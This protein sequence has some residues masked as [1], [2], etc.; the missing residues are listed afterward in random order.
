[1]EVL[2]LLV[3]QQESHA[4]QKRQRT[5]RPPATAIEQGCLTQTAA[6]SIICVKPSSLHSTSSQTAVVVDVV[7][8]T[9]A[10][11]PFNHGV[12]GGGLWLGAYSGRRTGQ[13]RAVFASTNSSPKA[14][15]NHYVATGYYTPTVAT[16]GLHRLLHTFREA[17]RRLRAV[18]SGNRRRPY[19]R[20]PARRKTTCKSR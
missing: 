18:M 2:T 17:C 13:L 8:T 1:M 9:P 11:P 4:S 14:L 7:D 3:G 16:G 12:G 15:V 10:N 19:G 20:Q 5:S 6:S